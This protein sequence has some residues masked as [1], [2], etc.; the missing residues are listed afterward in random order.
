MSYRFG[1]KADAERAIESRQDRLD[2]RYLR[3]EISEVDYH[4]ACD[5]LERQDRANEDRK[6]RWR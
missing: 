4:A 3:G 6:R 1:T 2:A 5:A